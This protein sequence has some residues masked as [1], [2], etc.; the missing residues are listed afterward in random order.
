VGRVTVYIDVVDGHVRVRV[1][2]CNLAIDNDAGIPEMWHDAV[3]GGQVRVDDPEDAPAIWAWVDCDQDVEET[4][5]W[6]GWEFGA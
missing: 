3:M 2:D 4:P 5:P 1:D 6:P